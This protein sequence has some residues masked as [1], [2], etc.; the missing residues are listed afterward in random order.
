VIFI[1]LILHI[2]LARRA[3]RQQQ[4]RKRAASELLLQLNRLHDRPQATP[5]IRLMYSFARP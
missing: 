1:R 4:A 2:M 5:A 3:A